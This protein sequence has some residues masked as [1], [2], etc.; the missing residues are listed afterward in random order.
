MPEED[1]WARKHL[2]FRKVDIE[3]AR[4]K[5]AAGPTRPSR[6]NVSH[7]QELAEAITIVQREFELASQRR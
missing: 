3:R 6:E 7:G 2:R 5:T 4:H 1:N